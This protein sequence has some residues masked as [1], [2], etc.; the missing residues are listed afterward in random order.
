MQSTAN[1]TADT[2]NNGSEKD[3]TKTEL[4]ITIQPGLQQTS[5]SNAVEK[6][7]AD[8]KSQTIAVSN[9]STFARLKD[10]FI[11]SK[12]IRAVTPTPEQRDWV[13][14]TVRYRLLSL[15]PMDLN[16]G[17]KSK[18]KNLFGWS[19]QNYFAYRAAETAYTDVPKD[20]FIPAEI[21]ALPLA[22]V[23]Y[24]ATAKGFGSFYKVYQ[25]TD[26]K[27]D[28]MSTL[29]AGHD[30]LQKR[31][32]KLETEQKELNAINR[33]LIEENK[34]L[35]TQLSATVNQQQRL[36][37]VVDVHTEVAGKT[38]AL[39]E[40]IQVIEG[41]FRKSNSGSALLVSSSE[42]SVA[43]SKNTEGSGL[44]LITKKAM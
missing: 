8:A 5:T 35:A 42:L 37:T 17:C 32:I 30:N 25:A 38:D 6:K 3:N 22:M 16:P 31:V 13:S 21:I 24:W 26:N 19:I 12:Y 34:A 28:Q 27:L 10:S 7:E 4:E 11:S 1:I 39:A 2:L 15:Y 41:L 18:T 9:K 33:K 43:D 44:E 23:A 36:S 40:K 14:Q 29:F 20:M